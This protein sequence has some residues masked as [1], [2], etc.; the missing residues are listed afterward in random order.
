MNFVENLVARTRLV[1]IIRLD[2]LSEA[3]DLSAA[4]LA[5]G[6][7]VQ[8]FTL[9]NPAALAALKRVRESIP[10]FRDGSGALGVGSVRSLAEAKAAI[11]AGAHFLVTPTLRLNV[12]SHAVEQGVPIMP[13]AYTPTEIATA[14][15]AGAAAVKV[16]PARQLGPGYIKDVLAP[17]P[18]LKLMPTGGI[19]LENMEQYF[20][21]GAMAVGIGVQ[22][23]DAEAV[24]RRDWQAV[25][26]IA[27]QYAAKALSVAGKD[28]R[29]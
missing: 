28:A 24:A 13:G 25:T 3:V 1:A 5:G 26:A 10:A 8:E 18:Y 23:F 27:T 16:F 20:R 19:N 17:M 7:A 4:L 15:E 9:T 2:D 14:W 29:T 21:N 11:D 6:V 22:T 12:I